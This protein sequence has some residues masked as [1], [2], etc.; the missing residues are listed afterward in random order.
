MLLQKINNK[1]GFTL[2][3]LMIVIAIIAILAVIVIPHACSVSV[4]TST[5]V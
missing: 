2:I 5:E 3:E 1:K 4:K